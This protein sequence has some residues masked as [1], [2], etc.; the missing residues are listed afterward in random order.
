MSLPIVNTSQ[1]QLVYALT[2]HLF[3]YFSVI[4]KSFLNEMGEIIRTTTEQGGGGSIIY[5][6]FSYRVDRA[7]PGDKVI[8]WSCTYTKSKCKARFRTD[9]MESVVIHTKNELTDGKYK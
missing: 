1:Y 7:R 4:F 5:D 3:I 9:D 8:D 2:Y 6:G